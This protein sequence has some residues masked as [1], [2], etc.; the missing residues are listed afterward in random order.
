MANIYSILDSI[1]YAEFISRYYL[2]P[3]ISNDLVNDS[4]PNVLEELMLEIN[5]TACDYPSTTPLMNS[6]EKL[7]CRQVKAVL[8]Y[9]VPNHHKY[10]EKYAHHMLFMFYPFRNEQDLKSKNTAT[11]SEKLQEP[12]VL[13]IINR[14]KQ[15]FEPYGD[16]VESALLNLH[17]NLTFNQDS[18]A[19]QENGQVEQLLEAADNLESEDPSEDAVILDDICIRL[20]LLHPLL[21]LITNLT[22]K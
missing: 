10:P 4:Q 13:D 6:K 8:R 22:L 9:H 1:C 17:T 18:F 2:L 14:N 5:H 20:L 7:K 3:K 21:Y 16:L 15:V 19:D 12:G 11:Y